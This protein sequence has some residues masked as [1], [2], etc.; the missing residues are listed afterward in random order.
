MRR[1]VFNTDKD[2]L[3]E[4]AVTVIKDT[5]INELSYRKHIV[6]GISGGKSIKGI[7]TLLKN[8]SSIPWERIHIFM[9]DERLV[10]LDSEESNFKQA[11]EYIIKELTIK[12]LLPAGNVHPFITA[13]GKENSGAKNYMNELKQ[14]G[15]RY[16]VILLGAGED[17]HVASLFP[18]H[19][20]VYDE[21]EYYIMINDSP[22][23]PPGRMSISRKLLQK[24]NTA[25]LLFFDEAKRA[26]F[27]AFLD[28]T[29]D[30]YS[31]PAKLVTSIDNAYILT[32]LDDR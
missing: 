18:R 21:S 30:C 28:D 20:S 24:A 17:G 22:K 9:V 4:Y 7:L 26:A 15:E 27:S 29:V 23:P 8:E 32:N 11:Q 19:S 5:F 2:T 25:M 31:C 14:Y 12:G 10:P 13:A 6:F 1:I 3:N 16:D